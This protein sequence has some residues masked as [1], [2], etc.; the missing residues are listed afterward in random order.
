MKVGPVVGRDAT[1][2][3]DAFS[4]APSTLP[5]SAGNPA[6]QKSKP[7][8]KAFTSVPKK[9][10]HAQKVIYFQQNV[11]HLDHQFRFIRSE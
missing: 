7:S 8:A 5:A 9:I 11:L 6:S 10:N 1:P 2:A 4:A 3:T